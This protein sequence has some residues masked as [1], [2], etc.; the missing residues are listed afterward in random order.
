MNDF[1]LQL[2]TPTRALGLHGG[3][4]LAL[5]TLESLK[6]GLKNRGV[7]PYNQIAV[8]RVDTIIRSE[9]RA[10][11]NYDDIGREV[12]EMEEAVKFAS[13]GFDVEREVREM[14]E[15]VKFARGFG[16][17]DTAKRVSEQQASIYENAARQASG[18]EARLREEPMR[19]IMQKDSEQYQHML[20]RISAHVETL[21]SVNIGGLPD[22][23]VGALPSV[24]IGGLPDVNVNA[25]ASAERLATQ[26]L[27]SYS[28]PDFGD[29][30]PKN[31]DQFQDLIG[32]ATRLA[33]APSTQE[34]LRSADEVMAARGVPV[35]EQP[36]DSADLEDLP[37]IP[38]LDWMLQLDR[39]TLIF[40]CRFLFDLTL[41]LS[42]AF[43]VQ[44]ALS[45]EDLDAED[46]PAVLTSLNVMLLFALR[47]LEKKE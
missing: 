8:V 1:S 31:F 42:S 26:A 39:D 47:A 46:L 27:K 6:I 40:W 32:R 23:S 9:R 7:G 20:D 5:E 2:L 16:L 29:L 17:A 15:A 45:D 43:G 28:A 36:L 30:L 14:E 19:Q 18:A 44:V 35:E 22:V 3:R 21:P 10:M 13:S 24:N 38:E 33:T 41:V 12:R 37:N 11:L 25:L 4:R 34:L